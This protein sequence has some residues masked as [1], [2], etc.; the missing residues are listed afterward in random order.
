MT[1][2]FLQKFGQ[3]NVNQGNDFNYVK[4][5]EQPEDLLFDMFNR[6]ETQRLSSIAS[7][8]VR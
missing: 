3:N 7:A 5:Y 8:N 1:Q 2:D 4:Q 6:D